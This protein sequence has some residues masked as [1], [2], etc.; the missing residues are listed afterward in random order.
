MKI[1]FPFLSSILIILFSIQSVLK[2]VP[3]EQR[4][5]AEA[6]MRSVEGPSLTI[7]NSDFALVKDSIGLKLSEGFNSV[8]YDSATMSLE[9]TSVVLDPVFPGDEQ[10][11]Y[12]YE[13]DDYYPNI[14]VAEQSYRNDVLSPS[15][16][17]SLFEGKSLEFLFIDR[18]GQRNTVLGKV[19]RS[20][21]QG[22]GAFTDPIIEVDGKLRFGLP[23]TAL[24]PSLG[25]DTLLKPRLE[26][27]IYSSQ[28][29]KGKA[30]LTYLTGGLS[31]QASYNL[32]LPE[33]G[34]LANLVGW[35]SIDNKSGRS[36]EN[37]AISLMAGEVHRAD[38]QGARNRMMLQKAMMSESMAPPGEVTQRSFDEFHLYTLPRE[39]TLRDKELKQVEFLSADN[40][41]VQTIYRYVGNPLYNGGGF[42]SDPDVTLTSPEN[43]SVVR[44][45][46][47]SESNQLGLPLPA[48][49]LRLYRKDGNS[50][51]FVGE[52]RIEHTPKNE[53]IEVVTGKA[54]DVLVKRLRTNFE[55]GGVQYLG[56]HSMVESFEFTI[57]NRKDE[58]VTVNIIEYLRGPSWEVTAQSH[59]HKKTS[60]TEVQWDVKVEADSEQKLT[61]TVKYTW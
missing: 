38:V 56:R 7:Y 19:V 52:D 44:R 58:S 16:M 24:F 50:V 28:P 13:E 42:Y 12:R 55:V 1:P 41:M 17:L 48:G 5:D 49:I 36:F 34:D 4:M 2:A 18:D 57:K 61:Y 39:V 47:N 59:E 20:G 22:G 21:Y 30:N 9:P 51:Q 32:L 43:V 6:A 33:K 40:L 26:W 23:G 60:A 11:D 54:F 53:T 45:I 27:K 29:F 31:W 37:S 10:T 15:Y 8:S 35:V 3:N 14:I 25:E 46:Y